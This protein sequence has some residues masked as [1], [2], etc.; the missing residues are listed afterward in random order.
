MLLTIQSLLNK[1]VTF[2]EPLDQVLIFNIIDRDVQML[3]SSSKRR[4]VA[5]SAIYDRDYV[6]DLVVG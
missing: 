3:V 4:V 1:G 2:G 5:K 6:S